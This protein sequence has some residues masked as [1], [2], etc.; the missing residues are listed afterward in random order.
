[1]PVVAAQE[2]SAMAHELAGLRGET[3]DEAIA[4]ALRAALERERQVQ[5]ETAAVL[6]PEQH[7]KVEQIMRLVRMADISSSSD[8]TAAL[9]DEN[10]LP[11]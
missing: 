11:A 6:T 2:I 8:P 5:A 3:V 7:A 1:M 9:Y 4:T 10:G